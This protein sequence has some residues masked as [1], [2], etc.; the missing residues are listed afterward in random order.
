V[1]QHY[2]AHRGLKGCQTGTGSQLEQKK[3][4]GRKLGWLRNGLHEAQTARNA[5]CLLTQDDDY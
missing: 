3:E 4:E 5:M 1:V 2:K